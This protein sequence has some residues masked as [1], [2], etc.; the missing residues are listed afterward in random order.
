MALFGLPILGVVMLAHAGGVPKSRH[1]K[2]CPMKAQPTTEAQCPN[3]C[4]YDANAPHVECAPPPS[5]PPPSCGQPE[6]TPPPSCGQPE[7]TPPPPTCTPPSNPQQDYRT[8]GYGQQDYR[9]QGYGQQDYRQQ[10]YRQQDYRQ[11]GNGQPGSKLNKL[12]GRKNN[13]EINKAPK[14]KLTGPATPANWMGLIP[15]ERRISELTIPGTHESAALHEPLIGVAKCQLL[16]IP[17]QLNAGIRY[18]DIRGR[19]VGKIKEDG[20]D[21]HGIVIHHGPIYQETGLNEVTADIYAF[22]QANPTETVIMSLK[23]EYDAEEGVTKAFDEIFNSKFLQPNIDK[24]YVGETIPTMAQARGKIILLRRFGSATVKGLDATNWADNT[25]FTINNGNATIA[26][27]DHYNIGDAGLDCDKFDDLAKK[28]ND[29]SSFFDAVASTGPDVLNINYSSGFTGSFYLICT[30]N[31]INPRL[32]KYFGSSNAIDDN[33]IGVHAS[34]RF[35]IIAVD[36]Q[37][38]DLPL[39]MLNTNFP[40]APISK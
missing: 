33:S 6:Y 5:E 2:G 8:Q 22:L 39:A 34:G 15:D 20:V 21:D 37:N 35:G 31:Y 3:S 25:T 32:N 7:Y 26:I 23:E 38:T 30:I 14:S 4:P 11:Q 12:P 36:Y 16:N 28:W 24:W 18:L 13:L 27:Q 10:D 17:D 1:K 19:R 40:G 29:I 9:Q